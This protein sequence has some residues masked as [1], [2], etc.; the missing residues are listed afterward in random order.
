MV[1]EEA[2]AS[3]GTE[4]EETMALMEDAVAV[5]EVEVAS[6]EQAEEATAT[7]TR[8]E[9]VAENSMKAEATDAITMDTRTTSIRRINNTFSR[10]SNNHLCPQQYH[11]RIQYQ[12]LRHQH[13]R[14]TIW[15]NTPIKWAAMPTAASG[16]TKSSSNGRD[17]PHLV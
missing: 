9:E 1:D 4:K 10:I 2:E 14:A 8:Q 11:C 6:M 5:E 15:T 16:V 13:T 7:T 3:A 12:A 17:R